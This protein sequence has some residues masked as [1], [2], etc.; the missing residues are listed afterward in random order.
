MFELW[1]RGD[2]VVG[3]R[4]QSGATFSLTRHHRQ[5]CDAAAGKQAFHSGKIK[6]SQCERG[7]WCQPAPPRP[8]FP[9]TS[10]PQVI[11]KP[12]QDQLITPGLNYLKKSEVS[13]INWYSDVF[14]HP[15]SPSLPPPLPPSLSQ[16]Y[17]LGNDLY[18]C[19]IGSVRAALTCQACWVG[20]DWAAL[21]VFT[22]QT[23]W[24]A[25]D[26]FFLFCFSQSFSTPKLCLP[27][28]S[29]CFV[30]P[31][32]CSYTEVPLLQHSQTGSWNICTA[33]KRLKK[34]AA[35]Q[36]AQFTHSINYAS[37]NSSCAL[38]QRGEAACGLNFK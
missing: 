34:D 30:F 15:L 37:K 4:L 14:Y 3:K 10:W 22:P 18:S 38:W 26:F 12:F 28:N 20:S 23:A 32:L 29:T 27:K 24:H 35:L 7:R 8:V 25:G 33:I 17:Y 11:P 16:I 21:F 6:L 9:S 1:V 31:S 5:L 2:N 36:P 19:G 13:D